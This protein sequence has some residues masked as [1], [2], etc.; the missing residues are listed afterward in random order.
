MVGS[1]MTLIIFAI[2][3][4][5][6]VVLESVAHVMIQEEKIFENST[7]SNQPTKLHDCYG[8]GKK[9]RPHHRFKKNSVLH[10][11]QYL[12][13]LFKTCSLASMVVQQVIEES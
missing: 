9:K 5:K 12:Q 13:E 6:I 3:V 8:R 11:E 2:Q 4:P 7:D 1:F 10:K